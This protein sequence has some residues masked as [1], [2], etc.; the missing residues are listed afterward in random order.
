MRG[1]PTCTDAALEPLTSK[2]GG[3]QRWPG[4]TRGGILW[5]RR[6]RRGHGG[7]RRPRTRGPR[8]PFLHRPSW[9]DDLLPKPRR[10]TD[11]GTAG[12][13]E[14]PPP[15]PCR[16]ADPLT[17]RGGGSLRPSSSWVF[18]GRCHGVVV[19]EIMPVVLRIPELPAG[20]FSPDV[21]RIV[22]TAEQER[23][24]VAMRRGATEVHLRRKKMTT[25]ALGRILQGLS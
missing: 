9:T 16:A 23:S 22:R 1:S 19:G 18:S 20:S 10:I 12:P 4:V 13:R 17:S 24:A 6:G 14:L 11:G 25:R 5:A 7:L 15:R 21:T 3:G 8:P 2:D